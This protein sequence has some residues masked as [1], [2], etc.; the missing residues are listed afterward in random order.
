M[1]FVTEYESCYN[2]NWIDNTAYTVNTTAYNNAFSSDGTYPDSSIS[3]IS[4]LPL[5]YSTLYER[6][7]IFY[8]TDPDIQRDDVNGSSCGHSSLLHY[9]GAQIVY[10]P[11]VYIFNKALLNR[12][13][14][15]GINYSVSIT[16]D[17]GWISWTENSTHF[18]FSG[19]P[20]NNTYAVEYNITITATD[21]T[22][23]AVVDSLYSIFSIYANDPP[24]IGN[25]DPKV[26]QTPN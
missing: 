18:Y 13:V 7:I 9:A 11:W 24:V 23:N 10:N 5:Y 1:C 14:I 26:I 25:M 19:T 8:L 16:P 3:T 17:N 22:T 2:Y 20:S 6:Y 4:T 15:T 21:Q 12:A